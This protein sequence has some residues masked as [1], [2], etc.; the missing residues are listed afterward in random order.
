MANLLVPDLVAGSFP[1]T[2]QVPP[3]SAAAL[4]DSATMAGNA[5][6]PA[7]VMNVFDALTVSGSADSS[8]A[9]DEGPATAMSQATPTTQDITIEHR[10]ALAAALHVGDAAGTRS[11]VDASLVGNPAAPGDGNIFASAGDSQDPL[12]A[13]YASPPVQEGPLAE[14]LG[15]GHGQEM[16]TGEESLAQADPISRGLAQ[17]LVDAAD[18]T[19]QKTGLTAAL[20]RVFTEIGQGVLYK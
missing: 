8:W 13:N 15:G 6:G 11:A 5:N 14:S 19:A 10:D 20:E 18:S 16:S 7:N 12:L 3:A 2:G 1:A 9:T 4:V 17:S